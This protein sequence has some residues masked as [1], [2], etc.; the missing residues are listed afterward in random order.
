[1]FDSIGFGESVDDKVLLWIDSIGIDFIGEG[2]GVELAVCACLHGCLF[3][4]NITSS[5]F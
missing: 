5:N 3:L 4:N 1:M 2:E